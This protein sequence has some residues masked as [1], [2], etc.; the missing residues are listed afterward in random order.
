MERAP[1][2]KEGMIWATTKDSVELEL[3]YN[4]EPGSISVLRQYWTTGSVNTRRRPHILFPLRGRLDLVSS[5]RQYGRQRKEWIIQRLLTST[6]QV[7]KQMSPARSRVDS[8]RPYVND[9]CSCDSPSML[10]PQSN[11]ERNVRQTPEGGPATDYI[12]ELLKM[13]KVIRNK[14]SPIKCGNKEVRA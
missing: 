1:V 2:A 4:E 8:K 9:T 13:L 12:T 3:R 6:R 10:S 11:Q 5:W 7:V 14:E